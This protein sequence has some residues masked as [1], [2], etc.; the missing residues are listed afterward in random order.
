MNWSIIL[1]YWVKNV[2]LLSNLT[3][4]ENQLI[5]EWGLIQCVA[6]GLL[7]VKTGQKQEGIKL[8]KIAELWAER[9]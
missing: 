8:L 1:L 3:D 2:E 6:T 5:W 4:V 9:F 7:L